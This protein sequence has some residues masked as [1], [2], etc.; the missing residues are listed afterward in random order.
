MADLHD[1]IKYYKVTLELTSP[2]LGTVPKNTQVFTTFIASKAAEEIEKRRKQAQ[3]EGK[4][5]DTV[6]AMA[7]GEPPT[8]ETLAAIMTEEP[9]GVVDSADREDKGST[10][11]V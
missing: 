4:N 2:M 11:A 5:P 8:K 7:G 3:K 10:G 9:E 1:R 6:P